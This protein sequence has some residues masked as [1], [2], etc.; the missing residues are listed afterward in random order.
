MIVPELLTLALLNMESAV[1]APELVRAPLTR[2]LVEAADI[3]PKLVI[4][5]EVK[6]DNELTVKVTPTGN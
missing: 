3:V 4:T 5:F 1:S 2:K 6:N